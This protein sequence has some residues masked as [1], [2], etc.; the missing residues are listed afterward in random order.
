MVFVS[1]QGGVHDR[2]RPPAA[3]QVTSVAVFSVAGTLRRNCSYVAALAIEWP[4]V[5]LP[6]T[7]SPH[8]AGNAGA[9]PVCCREA[10]R[11]LLLPQ[12]ADSRALEL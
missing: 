10:P 4:G 5:V 11:G 9:L 1:A 3:P 8:R 7:A 6:G 12:W 2:R